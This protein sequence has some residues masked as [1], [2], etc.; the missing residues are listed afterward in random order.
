MFN[1]TTT[2]AAALRI[3]VLCLSQPCR[4]M[5][6]EALQGA[7]EVGWGA[8]GVLKRTGRREL[9]GPCVVVQKDQ[10]QD[11]VSWLTL[12]SHFLHAPSQ[13]QHIPAKEEKA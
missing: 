7:V 9:S 10:K 12:Q 3:L 11:S 2:G 4:L 8:T 5:S 1:G 6:Y 13:S